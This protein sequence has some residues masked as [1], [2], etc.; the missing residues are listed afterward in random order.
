MTGTLRRNHDHVYIFW[1]LGGLE[2]N[3]EAVGK[4]E[5]LS[6]TQM[7][8]D[9]RLV[10]VGLGLVGSENLNP[11]GAL[12]G[13]RRSKNRHAIGARLLGGT[14]RGLEA[15]DHVVSAVAQ[16]LRLRVSL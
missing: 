16:I 4:A 15:D 3:R 7:R 13:F 9:R 1:W 2:V 5:N 10:E 12:R 14:A 6:L 11:V 8:L